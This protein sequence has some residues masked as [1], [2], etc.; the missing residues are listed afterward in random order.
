MLDVTA[1][2]PIDGRYRDK[3]G[4]SQL[5]SDNRFGSAVPAAVGGDARRRSFPG[6]LGWLEINDR[7]PASGS[8]GQKKRAIH[9]ERVG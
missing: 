3:S 5:P 6:T 8:Q 4:P 2:R 7:Q 9:I 1:D